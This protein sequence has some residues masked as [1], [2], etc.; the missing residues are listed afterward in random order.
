MA[1][2]KP[3]QWYRKTYGHFSEQAWNEAVDRTRDILVDWAKKGAI[4][5]YGDLITELG[6]L[7]WPDGPYTHHGSQV[8][9]LLG[10]ASV[11]EWVEDRPLVSALVISRDGGG[12]GDGFYGLCEEL[13]GDV[14]GS[15]EETK[16]RVWAREVARCHEYWRA[17]KR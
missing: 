14:I 2:K 11:A 7:D 16:D 4:G 1:S 10:D 9:K 15:S 6:M 8:G 5:T 12:P 17:E 3:P 13:L